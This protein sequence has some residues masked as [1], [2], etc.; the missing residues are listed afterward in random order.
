[1]NDSPPNK[2]GS[3]KSGPTKPGSAGGVFIAIFGL[4]GVFVGG[5]QGQPTIGFLG[6]LATGGLI[7]LALWW[8]Q[9]QR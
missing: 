6:G 8:K 4:I 5:F 2:S 7:S 3:E 1:M 9:R